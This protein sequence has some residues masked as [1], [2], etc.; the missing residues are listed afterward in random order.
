M[1]K[2]RI[3]KLTNFVVLCLGIGEVHYVGIADIE[4]LHLEYE[5]G[6]GTYIL[7]IKSPKKVSSFAFTPHVALQVHRFGVLQHLTQC[8]DMD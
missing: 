1:P 7:L 5:Q 8:V 2:Q 3:Y 4:S 6:D